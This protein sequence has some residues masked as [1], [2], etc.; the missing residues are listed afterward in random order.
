MSPGASLCDLEIFIKFW[1]V[2]DIYYIKFARTA[3]TTVYFVLIKNTDLL[4]IEGSDN[5]ESSTALEICLWWLATGH[6]N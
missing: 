4:A 6:K 5:G 1:A 3:Q 2:K